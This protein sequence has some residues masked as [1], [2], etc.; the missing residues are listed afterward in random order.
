MTFRAT[1]LAAAGAAALMIGT[2]ASPAYAVTDE[3]IANDAKTTDDVVT[4]RS[5]HSG[6]AL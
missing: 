6:A 4:V 5:R 3:D 2:A 1:L